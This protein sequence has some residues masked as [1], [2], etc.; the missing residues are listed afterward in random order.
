MLEGG[1]MLDVGMVNDGSQD[2]IYILVL[3]QAC[4]IGVAI[5]KPKPELRQPLR[6]RH[7]QMSPN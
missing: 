4:E 7:D 1:N 5:R 2:V 3:A 6:L